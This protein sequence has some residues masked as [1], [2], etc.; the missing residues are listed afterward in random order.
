[1]ETANLREQVEASCKNAQ[2]EEAFKEL[3]TLMGANG[4]KVPYSA[5]INYSK[6]YIVGL[7]S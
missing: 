4:G 6:I 5:R 7:K 1:M 3:L 2:Q